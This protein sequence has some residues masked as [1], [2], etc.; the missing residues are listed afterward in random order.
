MSK[1][2]IIIKTVAVFA[3]ILAVAGFFSSPRNI[4][5]FPKTADAAEN[6]KERLFRKMG[7]LPLAHIAEPID[8]TLEDLNG[9]P[10]RLSD[11]RGNIVFLNFWT[12]W[13]PDC[14][15]EMPSMQKLHVSFKD[16]NFVMVAVNLKEPAARV[17]EFFK[18]NHLTF[19]SLL[20]SNREVSAQMGIR[21]IPTTF[22]IGSSGKILG[23]IMG[24]RQWDSKE[25][26]DLFNYL[27]DLKDDTSS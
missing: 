24:P 23:T 7:I 11:F 5:L 8:F 14:R 25:S 10:M 27:I 21:A 6:K 26:T 1:Y 9:N 19:I 18:K 17:K 16:K 12:T 15:V 13:C 2:L 22:I 4:N 3:V 20:D